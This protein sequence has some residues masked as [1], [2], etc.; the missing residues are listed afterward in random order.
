MGRIDATIIVKLSC[1]S[2]EGRIFKRCFNLK[3]R[4]AKEERKMNSV[5]SSSNL[6]LR[7]ETAILIQESSAPLFFFA[8]EMGLKI[9]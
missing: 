4:I 5:N 2:I 6:I 8:F 7:L 1:S 3:Q 9:S